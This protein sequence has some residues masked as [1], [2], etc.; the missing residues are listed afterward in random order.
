MCVHAMMV[1]WSSFIG[2][3]LDVSRTY[4]H[5]RKGAASKQHLYV[6]GSGSGDNAVAGPTT[7][8]ALA[9]IEESLSARRESLEPHPL[10]LRNF[11]RQTDDV[12]HLD[13][14]LPF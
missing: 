11:M 13:S 7:N 4:K 9:E 12:D 5:K 1:P 3:H 8:Q 10:Q 14:D 2:K 6:V